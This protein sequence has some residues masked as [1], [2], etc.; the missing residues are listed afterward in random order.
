MNNNTIRIVAQAYYGNKV[1]T[2]IK[3][4]D[5]DRFILGY[6][7]DSIEV[8]EK[9]DRTIVHL[10]NLENIVLVYNKDFEKR[11]LE[12]KADLISNHD[13]ELKPLAVI[14]EL[15]MKLYSR[16]FVC[17]VDEDGE[18]ASLEDG[19]YKKFEKYLAE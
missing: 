13:Y 19:D 15:D 1:N 7:E 5:V 8:T 9:I 3:K 18:L 2:T 17:R 11:E 10:P 14:P 4:E 16:C 12:R 6:M